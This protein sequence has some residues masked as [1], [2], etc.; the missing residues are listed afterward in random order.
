MSS[1]RKKPISSMQKPNLSFQPKGSPSRSD[2]TDYICPSVH[3]KL[4]QIRLAS[5]DDLGLLPAHASD[6]GKA[7]KASLMDL[8]TSSLCAICNT[9][10][11]N[12]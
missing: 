9:Y 12:V 3:A 8:Y 5:M 4:P 7:Y 2:Y 1:L 6:Q 10:A 11:E